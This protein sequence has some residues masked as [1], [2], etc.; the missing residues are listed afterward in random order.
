MVPRATV[1]RWQVESSAP[2]RMNH[3]STERSSLQMP[4][5]CEPSAALIGDSATAT[6]VHDNRCHHSSRS[7]H[8]W[9]LAS[10]CMVVLQHAPARRSGLGEAVGVP[11]EPTASR[12]LSARRSHQGEPPRSA[13]GRD[14]RAAVKRQSHPPRQG[15][16]GCGE[17]QARDPRLEGSEPAQRS[18][19]SKSG[20]DQLVAYGAAEGGHVPA[21]PAVLS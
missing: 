20:D 19:G 15:G 9:W 18:T 6:V 14:G 21:E 5:P 2:Q 10:H 11:P 3:R 1:D 12:N 4:T 7:L 13:A 16:R 8:T 17:G